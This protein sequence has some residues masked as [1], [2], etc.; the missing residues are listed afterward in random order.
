LNII[1]KINYEY[2]WP[3]KRVENKIK[4]ERKRV[5]I[6]FFFIKKEGLKSEGDVGNF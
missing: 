5:E 6:N 3:W 1:N 2:V 4:R